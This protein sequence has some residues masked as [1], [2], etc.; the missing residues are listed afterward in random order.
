MVTIIKSILRFSL[1]RRF[2]LARVQPLLRIIDMQKIKY[3]PMEIAI[4][5]AMHKTLFPWTYCCFTRRPEEL[6]RW[7]KVSGLERL[8][9]LL[10]TGRGV[11]LAANHHGPGHMIDIFL[12][13]QGYKVNILQ[14]RYPVYRRRMR[15]AVPEINM[16]INNIFTRLDSSP[17]MMQTMINIRDLLRRGEIVIT[18]L[19]G[20]QGEASLTLKLMGHEH[21]F[22]FAMPLIASLSNAII[23]PVYVFLKT[24]GHIEI[25]FETPLPEQRPDQSPHEYAKDIMNTYAIL[26]Q[27]HMEMKPGNIRMERLWFLRNKIGL[28]HIIFGNYYR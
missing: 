18:A 9:P 14:A 6:D 16:C 22:R 10:G 23:V 7:V 26:L 20:Y 1:A 4:E 2:A 17:G 27:N 24:D 12:A 25:R 28:F 11:L 19:D 8:T 3:D 21:D 13:A 15:Y 5:M